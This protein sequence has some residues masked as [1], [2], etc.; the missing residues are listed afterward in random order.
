MLQFLFSNLLIVLTTIIISTKSFS[1]PH[2][3]HDHHH[4]LPLGPVSTVAAMMTAASIRRRT[5]VSK[6]V[7][8]TD[9]LR[10]DTQTNGPHCTVLGGRCPWF[11]RV[12]FKCEWPIIA[13]VP[14]EYAARK[15]SSP[16]RQGCHIVTPIS[17]LGD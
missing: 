2:F 8:Q 17:V 15:W 12:V 7:L 3:C 16:V 4:P 1:Y 5:L 10:H 6:E 13:L 11:V 9:Y 14:L